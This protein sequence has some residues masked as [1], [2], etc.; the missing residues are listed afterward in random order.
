MAGHSPACWA[1]GRGSIRWH[2]RPCVRG[3]ALA[4]TAG[5]RAGRRQGEARRLWLMEYARGA[6]CGCRGGPPRN[7]TR[8][9]EEVSDACVLRR[10]WLTTRSSVDSGHERDSGGRLCGSVGPG[11]EGASAQ[12]RRGQA[13]RGV[14][15]PTHTHTHTLL[16]NIGS[17]H[18]PSLT[19]EPLAMAEGRARADEAAQPG[20]LSWGWT[21]LV[22]DS[23][24]VMDAH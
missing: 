5:R 24:G 20:R 15:P 12:G 10:L 14:G 22:R 11:R 19:T 16:R 18:S 2:R 1:G 8:V 6:L 21:S 13:E 23:L 7:V 9:E 17:L 3:M 4:D